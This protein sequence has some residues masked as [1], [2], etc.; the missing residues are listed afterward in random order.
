MGLKPE[1]SVD[2]AR[3]V[4]RIEHPPEHVEGAV[5]SDH[6]RRDVDDDHR[7]GL[8]RDVHEA[9]VAEVTAVTGRERV[10]DVV[11]HHHTDVVVAGPTVL[12]VH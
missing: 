12:A 7:F 2:R 10:G 8:H 9:G 11:R 4:V 3:V 5:R 6:G 1:Q